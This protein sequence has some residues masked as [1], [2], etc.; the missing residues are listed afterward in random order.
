MR[1]AGSQAGVGTA[2]RTCQSCGG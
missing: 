1:D 2:L